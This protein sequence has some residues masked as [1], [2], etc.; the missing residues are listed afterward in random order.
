MA[1][2]QE[3]TV[4]SVEI[5]SIGTELLIGRIQDTNSGWLAREI[6][7]L[8]GSIGRITIVGDDRAQ[9]VEALRGAL[10]RGARTIVTTGGLGPTP[11]DLTVESVST[12]LGVGTRVDE[13]ALDDFMQRREIVEADVSPALRKM[14]QI[15]ETG[16]AL[17]S[18][19]GWAPCIRVPYREAT[20][21]LLPGP[22][23]EMEALF[24][25]YLRDYFAGAASGASVARRV[26][27]N[28]WESQV[29]PLAR[30]VMDAFPGT[31]IKGYIA[32]AL[33]NQQ[34]LPLDVVV[35]GSSQAEAQDKL[36]Q[37]VAMLEQLVVGVGGQ[38]SG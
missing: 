20:L 4:S 26:Y 16:E 33:A 3:R 13:A 17:L 27:V 15:P 8:G 10:D 35:K 29:A 24:E 19:A 12:L 22:P 9:I 18:P 21:F 38:L 5:F 31:Y 2:A 32:L 37:A 6:S 30:Q 36:E 7:E 23:G 34:R 1:L 11:D 25:R 14:A 28:M